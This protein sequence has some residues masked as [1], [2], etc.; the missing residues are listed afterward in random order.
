[1]AVKILNLASLLLSHGVYECIRGWPRQPRG[2]CCVLLTGA[3]HTAQ[4]GA[5]FRDVRVQRRG[6]TRT[7]SCDEASQEMPAFLLQFARLC[8]G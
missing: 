1:M 2:R 7:G 4:H 5:R 3:H 8:S 6:G